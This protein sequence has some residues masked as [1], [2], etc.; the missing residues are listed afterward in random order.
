MLANAGPRN[1]PATTDSN[2]AAS[3]RTAPFLLVVTEPTA[4]GFPTAACRGS[5][6]RSRH[7]RR[8]RP[9]AAAPIGLACPNDFGGSRHHAP[10]SGWILAVGLRRHRLGRGALPDRGKAGRT[11][12]SD[13][14]AP[15]RGRSPEQPI[16]TFRAVRSA[17]LMAHTF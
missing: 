11:G 7:G 1:H 16:K 15:H 5:R 10:P 3:R 4:Y 17:V 8:S 14:V 9:C 12:A 13:A 2:G 6:A